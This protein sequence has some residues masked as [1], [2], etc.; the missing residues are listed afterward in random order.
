M[1]VEIFDGQFSA[2]SWAAAHGDALTEA[3][4]HGGARNWDWHTH[5]WGVIF[6]VE[7]DDDEAWEGFRNSPAV[8]AALD[9]VP[10]PVSGLL[11]YKG[12]GGSA[13]RPEPRRPRPLAGAGAAALPVPITEPLDDE[14]E[15]IFR[16]ARPRTLI[17]V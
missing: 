13:S 4:L 7:F 14:F 10:D 6:E 2:A 1:S 17:T 5:S 3:A 8:T 15:G 11:I 12:R 16:D 9:A